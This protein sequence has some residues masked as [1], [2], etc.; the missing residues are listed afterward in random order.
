MKK[1]Y[2]PKN[3]RQTAASTGDVRAKRDWN[4][5]SRVRIGVLL[6]QEITRVLASEHGIEERT[7]VGSQSAGDN[8]V[9]A[10]LAD[11]ESR[12][13]NELHAAKLRFAQADFGRCELCEQWIEKKR[14]IALPTARTCIA[15]AQ[16]AES[17]LA[18][19]S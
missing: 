16:L 5:L 6:D 14:I 12:E 11:L 7:K 9:D 2:K 15:C 19:R 13:L 17:S 18:H 4:A 10:T 3:S 1:L 8:E